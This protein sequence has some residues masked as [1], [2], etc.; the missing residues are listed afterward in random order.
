[1]GAQVSR[2]PTG[3]VTFVFTDIEGSTRLWELHAHVM[4]DVVARH[5]A[6]IGG[7]ISDH[8]G[9][10]FRTAG[11]SFCA[12]FGSAPAALR[13]TL[14]AQ[15]VLA[16]EIWSAL[17]LPDGE[18]LRVRFALHSSEVT[19]HGGDYSGP[20]LNRVARLLAAAHGGQTLLSFATAELVREQLLDD[21]VLHE[22]GEYHLRDLVQ[23]ERI[24]QLVTPDLPSTFPPLRIAGSQ[25][26]SIDSQATPPTI[27]RQDK[28]PDMPGI[29]YDA[30]LAR[31]RQLG[32]RRR[33]RKKPPESDELF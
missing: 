22:L 9:V 30:V 23:P 33:T 11:D 32:R 15:R 19:L 24:Y 12:A 18:V 5:D 1:M 13:A 3:M 27:W 4:P 16:S 2:L 7:A 21:M 8:D 20:P 26:S 25:S 14:I 29:D 17:G 10:V 31:D 28:L 6:I